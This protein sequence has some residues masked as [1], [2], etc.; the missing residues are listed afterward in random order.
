MDNQAK[1]DQLGQ[2]LKNSFTKNA[3]CD[4]GDVLALAW[5]NER[6]GRFK[7]VNGQIEW[8]E[9]ADEKYQHVFKSGPDEVEIRADRQ[10][11]LPD[12]KTPNMIKNLLPENTIF[13]ILG[14]DD[15]RSYLKHGLRFLSNF[16]ISP[17]AP[18]DLPLEG[19][20]HITKLEKF[21]KDGTF[22]GKYAGPP[23]KTYGEELRKN[24][25]ERWINRYMPR[26]SGAELKVPM[27]LHEDGTIISTKN[28]NTPFTHFMKIPPGENQEGWGV[29][30][31]MCMELAKRVGLDTAEHA[32]IEINPELEP[33]VLIERFDIPDGI[34]ET[35]E[36]MMIQDFCTLT[37]MS[38][39]DKKTGSLESIAKLVKELSTTPDADIRILFKRAVLSVAINDADMHRK[40]ISMMHK[41][42]PE[43]EVFTSVRLSTAYDITSEIHDRP[44]EEKQS[45]SLANKKG[46]F[47]EKTILQFAKNIGLPEDEAK[48]IMQE[49]METVAHEAVNIARNLPEI[50]KKHQSCQY[51]ADRIATIAVGN[52]RKMG[53][54]APEWDDV[55]STT[56][57][58][59]HLIPREKIEYM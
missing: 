48:Q 52:A 44:L 49:T 12:D 10:E 13:K 33:A 47:K 7:L 3:Y 39:D 55:A 18:Y 16:S 57:I 2:E 23:C 34:D 35:E 26:Y 24:L 50:A 40:N 19:D 4:E 6:I 27:C 59:H 1:Q 54:K 11:P 5:H 30:E 45:L 28:I 37:G 42:D 31:W 29:N 58:S 53:Y 22:N 36:Y 14:H 51:T 21:T 15:Q 56:K 25:A 43:Q 46:K 32:L 8:L 9:F 17:N 41:Y 38:P 20:Y